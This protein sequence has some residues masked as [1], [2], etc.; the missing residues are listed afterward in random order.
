MKVK[1]GVAVDQY[2]LTYHDLILL[3]EEYH[4]ERLE[5][6]RAQQP[7]LAAKA[8]ANYNRIHALLFRFGEHSSVVVFD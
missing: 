5:W 6:E 8:A 3:L 7:T 1:Y 4:H 2:K